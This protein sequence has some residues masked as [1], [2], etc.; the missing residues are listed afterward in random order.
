MYV[1]IQHLTADVRL[2]NTV[3]TVQ[4]V[5]SRGK[6][7]VQHSYFLLAWKPRANNL[8]PTIVRFHCADC[9]K[10]LQL[11]PAAAIMSAFTEAGHCGLQVQHELAFKYM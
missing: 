2:P 5:F 8:A 4:K 1:S 7:P 11:P 9:Q 6:N 10:P 3:G